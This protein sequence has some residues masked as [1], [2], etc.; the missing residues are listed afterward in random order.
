MSDERTGELIAYD[1]KAD[2]EQ[3]IISGIATTPALDR[4]G[5]RIDPLGASFT[6]P[7]PLLLYHDKQLP[8][9][10]VVFG[11]PTP[12]GIPFTAQLPKVTAAG[13][14]RDRVELA[15]HSITA[16]LFSFVSIG[17][18]ALAD[19]MRPNANGGFDFLKTEILELSLVT[20]P[21]NPGAAITDYK[22]LDLAVSGRH[23]S[24]VADAVTEPKIMQTISE[25][26]THWSDQRQPIVARMT[27]MMSPDRTLSDVEA[28][29]YDDLA[30][31]VAGIDGQ[32]E[33]LRHLERANVSAARALTT[34]LTS[35][36]PAASVVRPSTISVR[37]A[38]LPPGILFVRGAM[39]LARAKGDMYQALQFAA[40]YKDTTPEVELWVKAA[41]L[42]GTTTDAAWAGPL[43]VVQN[44]TAEFV[45]L[46]RPKTIIGRIPGLREVPFNV[47]VPAQ[48]AGGTYG[49]VGQ[50][51]PKPVTKLAFGSV[52]MAITKASGIIV[53]TDELVKISSPSAEKLCRDD[54]IAGIAQFLDT[55]FIDPAVAA[56]ATVN[57]ASITNGITPITTTGNPIRDMHGDP[58]GVRDGQR[59]AR[60]RDVHHVG[61]Q[62][63]HPRLVARCDRRA[64]VSRRR[65]ERRQ[66]GRHEHRHQQHGRTAGHRRCAVDDPAGR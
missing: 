1:I 61:N 51:K 9:G 54:M 66:R 59:T 13:A 60:R 45:G 25:Q 8:I 24:A 5:D 11:T 37:S 57:P 56:V 32:L 29:S 2:G 35:A 36:A 30:A 10:S 18:R 55:Q 64:D 63:V 46:L 23:P 48:T 50:A 38:E 27:E 22:A 49:W 40:Q 44:I 28:K 33:R 43:A 58:V 39:C 52:S 65:R 19:A 41:V 16:G 12:A 3:R 31:R 21:S 42:P 62:R 14:L 15:W 6:N 7:V 34:P 53:L 17:Y 26:I 20:V 4:R 47:A